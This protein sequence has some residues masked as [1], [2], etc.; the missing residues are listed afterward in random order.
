MHIFLQGPRGIGKSTV[1]TKTLEI[2]QE[3][4]PL[5]IGGFY[6]W[7]GGK[8]DPN[9][10]MRSADPGNPKA[11]YRLATWDDSQGR[12]ICDNR[13][14]DRDGA[15]LL[16]ER[17]GA[18]L[19]IMDE[20]GFL[21]SKAHV[22]IRAVYDTL[23]GDIPVFGVLRQGEIPWQTQIAIDPRVLIYNVDE[24]NRDALPKELA[25]NLLRSMGR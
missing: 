20:L 2:I 13:A 4:S 23:S 7:R 18:D 25:K 5:S 15:R 14:F 11:A 22:F 19:I 10:Y 21:E 17:L 9:I 24:Q 16:G 3:G 6:T 12:L 8:G 1:I